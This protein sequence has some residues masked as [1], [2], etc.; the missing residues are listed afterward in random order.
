MP[1]IYNDVQFPEYFEY[2]FFIWYCQL[3]RKVDS[4]HRFISISYEAIESLEVCDLT[5]VA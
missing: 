1:Y 4:S 5:R 3:L 2:A